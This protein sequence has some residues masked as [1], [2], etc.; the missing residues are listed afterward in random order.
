VVLPLILAWAPDPFA[1][2]RRISTWEGALL[3]T[4]VAALGAIAVSTTERVTYLVF[5][6]LIWSAFR[7][8]AQGATLSVAIAAGV[9]VGLTANDV[10][11][12]S[13]QPIDHQT[14]STQAYI[15]IAALTTLL[16]SAVVSERERSSRDLAEAKRHEGERAVEERQR[17]AR[18][19]HDSVSQAL[20]STVLH[21]R[22]AQKALEQ[23]GLSRSGRL[24]LELSAI[25]DLTRDA[26]SE[27]RTLIFE[28]GRDPTDDG[29]V[30]ALAE[31][32]A[33]LGRLD[34][35]PIDVRGPED[36]LS[37]PRRAERQLFGIGREAL[38]N[39]V[40]HADAT[41]AWVTV[42]ARPGRVIVEIRDD[43]HGFDPASGHPG[44][45]GL[46]S[47]RSRASEIGGALTISS[48]PG[49]GTVVRVEAP[50]QTAQV[51]D[52]A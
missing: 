38:A 44:H 14:L 5:P 36:G 50:A 23:E 29:L 10:G 28:L 40:K 27:M 49:Q 6:P 31:H 45:F 8:G 21:N 42:E 12:F 48:A 15:A 11:P 30:A 18:D 32:A 13:K 39:V 19:L 47:M 3:I 4:T 22:T 35:L 2:W 52:D 16:L 43:G 9:T 51:S 33:R 1:A 37:L 24:G 17:I 46:D 7:F 34:G 41:T 20:F 25:G 26:Q